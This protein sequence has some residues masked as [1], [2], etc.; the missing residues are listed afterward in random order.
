MRF[1]QEGGA[2]IFI[3]NYLIKERSVTVKELNIVWI[4]LKEFLRYILDLF[5]ILG[6]FCSPHLECTGVN[7]LLEELSPKF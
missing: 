1:F 6:D 7:L 3:V 2:I 4:K 5:I